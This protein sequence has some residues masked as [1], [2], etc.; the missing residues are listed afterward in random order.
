MYSLGCRLDYFIQT[1]MCARNPKLSFEKWR[2]LTLPVSFVFSRT[3]PSATDEKFQENVLGMSLEARKHLQ[4]LPLSHCFFPKQHGFRGGI[5]LP[6]RGASKAK[7]RMGQEWHN[8]LNLRPSNWGPC[9]TSTLR[10]KKENC[11]S[12]Q[13]DM[14]SSA[15]Y[16]A[17]SLTSCKS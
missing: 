17:F 6:R 1:S 9:R 2:L 11:S 15:R 12:P 14:S 8:F 13:A 7:N 16:G 10:H 4:A 3:A 5:P